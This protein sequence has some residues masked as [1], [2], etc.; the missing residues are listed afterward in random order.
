MLA[1][2]AMMTGQRDLAMKHIRAMVAEIPADFLNENA[3]Q[4]EGNVAMALEVMVR[5]GLWDE[6]LAEPDKYG[7]KMWFTRAFHHAARAIAYAAKGDT[8]NARKAQTIF[9]ERAKLVPK[10]ASLANNSCE[11]LLGVVTPMV[12]GEILV[13]E[14]KIDS[15][16]EQL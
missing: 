8:V 1:Y 14:G 9:V 6:I 7:D 10:E 5:L 13:A 12:E 4:A 11:A 2:A 15:G 3:L 16:I